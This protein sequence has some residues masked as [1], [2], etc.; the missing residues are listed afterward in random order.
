MYC[1][2]CTEECVLK[3]PQAALQVKVQTSP[4]NRALAMYH[5]NGGHFGA[6]PQFIL[7][8]GLL[9]YDITCKW[10]YLMYVFLHHFHGNE[11]V[12]RI[13]KLVQSLIKSTTAD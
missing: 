10:W 6:C 13:V 7:C 4:M 12:C 3:D 8:T 9:C 1:Y 11:Y 5:G 2:C